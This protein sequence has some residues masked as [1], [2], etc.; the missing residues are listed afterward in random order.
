MSYEADLDRIESIVT[1]LE[2]EDLELDRALRL[3]EEGVERLRSAA[4][5]LADAEGRLRLLVERADGSF[6]LGD[7][8][9]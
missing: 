6:V 3:F 2:R 8:T 5:A 1:E 7:I 9:G 4:A